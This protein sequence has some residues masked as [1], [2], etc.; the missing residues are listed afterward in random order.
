MTGR[1]SDTVVLAAG[2]TGGH[3]FPAQALARELVARGSRVI[4]ITDRRGGGFGA[5][6]DRVETLRIRAAGIAGRGLRGK[7]KGAIDLGL[8]YLQARGHLRRI[9]PGTVVGFGGYASVPTVMAAAHLGA[10]VLLHEQ[11]A[12]IGRANRLLASRAEAI[13]TSFD[14]PRGLSPAFDPKMATTGNPVRP[15][16]AAIG[17]TPYPTPGP[18]DTLHLLVTGGSQGAQAFNDV[19]P[20]AIA[21]LPERLRARIEISQQV[22]GDVI[23]QVEA[24]YRRCGVTA[25]LAGFFD[26]VPERLA[27]AHLVICRA[28][29]ST[30]AE[31]AA[32]GRPAIL[33]P[34]PHAT[35]DHQTDNGRALA[36]AGAAWLLPEPSLTAQ[37]LS[38]RLESLLCAPALLGRAAHCAA[39]F[40]RRDAAA[41]LADLVCGIELGNGGRDDGGSHRR[42]AAE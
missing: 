19:V 24:A 15:E 33:V 34:Y 10:R 5:E 12:V 7:I 28:G 41:R 25:H 30:V 14:R 26:D 31:L 2:G 22:R 1:P 6:L 16:I 4:L 20:A 11:N 38:E 13:A 18:D 3:M 29:A 27:R 37:G 32:A 39:A 17:E 9:R 35:D 36:D 21:L 23:G 42:E 40:G 8:G